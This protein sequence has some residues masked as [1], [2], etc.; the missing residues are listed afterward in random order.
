RS[1]ALRIGGCHACRADATG[2]PAR[3]SP[4]ESRAPVSQSS[5]VMTCSAVRKA[6]VFVDLVRRLASVGLLLLV[7]ACVA[8]LHRGPGPIGDY[9][10]QPP[11]E[12]HPVFT[13]GEAVEVDIDAPFETTRYHEVSSLRFQSSGTHGGP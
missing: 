6:P 12:A 3:R 13:R 10:Y 4:V 2:S 5:E 8:H 9:V 7:S 11:L 1:A